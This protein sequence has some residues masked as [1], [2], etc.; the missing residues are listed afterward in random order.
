MDTGETVFEIDKPLERKEIT[1]EPKTTFNIDNNGN[2]K[3]NTF[4]GFISGSGKIDY[5]NPEFKDLLIPKDKT[6]KIHMDGYT[7]IQVRSR[8]HKKKRINKK[9]AKIYGYRPK[10][11]RVEY[12]FNKCSFKH[13]EF[14]A[15]AKM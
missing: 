10:K 8:V 5:I 12:I 6:F 13:G 2:F 14:E 7:E 4:G 9:W 1:Y 3:I 11:V 15:L